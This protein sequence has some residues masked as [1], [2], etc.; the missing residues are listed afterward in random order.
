MRFGAAHVERARTERAEGGRKCQIGN[1][2][3]PLDMAGAV[4][5]KRLAARAATVEKQHAKPRRDSETADQEQH[6]QQR[7]RPMERDVC[8]DTKERDRH[9]QAR[10]EGFVE[11][12]HS[13]DIGPVREYRSLIRHIVHSTVD[14]RGGQRQ[15]RRSQGLLISTGVGHWVDLTS[16]HEGFHRAPITMLSPR[17]IPAF[18]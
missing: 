2:E 10:R 14:Q 4:Q 12:A 3:H 8:A 13:H 11:R 6:G 16:E 5:I 9:D 1:R 7:I 18:N 15:L 17:S